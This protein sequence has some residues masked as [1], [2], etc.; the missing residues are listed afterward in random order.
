MA[1]KFPLYV[2]S[3][4]DRLISD[5]GT[6]LS[7]P[8]VDLDSAGL[9]AELLNSDQPAIVWA[10]GNLAE[11]PMDPLWFVDFEV[12]A[13]TSL[14]PAQYRSMDIVSQLLQEF[15]VGMT[16]EVFDYSGAVPGSAQEGII[17]VTGVAAAPSQPDRLSG[18]RMLNVQARAVRA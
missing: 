17:Y 10:I 15:Y 16:V 6:Q 2:K 18:I 8:V 7:L 3:S 9:V 12:G 4:L 13:K 5:L 1:H 11:E 14:D